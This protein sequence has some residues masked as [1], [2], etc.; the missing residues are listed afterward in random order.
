MVRRGGGEA[1]WDASENW[2]LLKTEARKACKIVLLR[3]DTQTAVT[4]M[5]IKRILEKK[6]H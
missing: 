1:A 2:H 4:N 6:I 5:T 3:N